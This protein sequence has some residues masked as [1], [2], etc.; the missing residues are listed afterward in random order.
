L[1]DIVQ[2]YQNPPPP[3]RVLPEGAPTKV[4]VEPPVIRPVFP[5]LEEE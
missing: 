1:T 2:F 5:V 4:Q 3:Y